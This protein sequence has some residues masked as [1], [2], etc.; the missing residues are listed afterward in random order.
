M[1]PCIPQ[2]WFELEVQIF[3]S[4]LVKYLQSLKEFITFGCPKPVLQDFVFFSIFFAS[5][6]EFSLDHIKGGISDPTFFSRRNM[7]YWRGKKCTALTIRE[8]Q[9]FRNFSTHAHRET[10]KRVK[11]GA[12]EIGFNYKE[13]LHI[14]FENP[15]WTDF[16]STH[17]PKHMFMFLK[18]CFLLCLRIA[19]RLGEDGPALPLLW[20]LVLSPCEA[21][22]F[23]K[24]RGWRGGGG[25]TLTLI[26]WLTGWWSGPAVPRAPTPQPPPPPAFRRTHRR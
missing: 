12:M 5:S 8:G 10:L 26:G 7:I 14:F 13:S 24:D 11:L 6:E 22:C 25:H 2:V 23:C 4:H 17:N 1:P 21:D 18:F 19:Y 20:N 16:L 3:V 9:F 15:F